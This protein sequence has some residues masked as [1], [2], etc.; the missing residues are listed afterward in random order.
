MSGRGQT[1]GGRGRRRGRAHRGVHEV[2][3]H[4]VPV[5]KEEFGQ[6]NVA[7]QVG[8]AGIP[9]QAGHTAMGALAREMAGA[10]REFTNLL[11]VE[12]QARENT[13]ESRASFLTREF[14]GAKPDELHGGPERMSGS[15]KL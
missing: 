9:G 4:E 1:H 15:A 7:E 6:A 13:A 8:Q 5:Q 2:L 12:N 10:L 3:V 11:R 14:L